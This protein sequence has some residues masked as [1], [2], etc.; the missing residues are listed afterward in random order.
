[1]MVLLV[2][3]FTAFHTQGMRPAIYAPRA[4]CLRAVPHEDGP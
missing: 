4:P 3:P 1:M 2:V